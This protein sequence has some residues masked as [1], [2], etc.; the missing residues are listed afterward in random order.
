VAYYPAD[1]TRIDTVALDLARQIRQQYTI[2]YTP[3]AVALDGAYRTIRVTA[4]S[5]VRGERLSVRT[6][7]GYRA[8]PAATG[9]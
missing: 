3:A 8:N 1:I 2:G 4:A 6:R 9:R 7:A 5:P